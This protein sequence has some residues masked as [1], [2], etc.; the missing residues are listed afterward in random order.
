MTPL[1]FKALRLLADGHFHSGARIARRLDRSRAAVS[2]TLKA[3]GEMGVE[4][5]SVP[6]KGSPSRTPR[7]TR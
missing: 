2:D 7:A 3:A 1:T 5:F 4:V 6:G